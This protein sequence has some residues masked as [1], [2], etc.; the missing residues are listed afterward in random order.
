M[1]EKM[2]PKVVTGQKVGGW[3]EAARKGILGSIQSKHW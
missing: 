1:A 3:W 2:G